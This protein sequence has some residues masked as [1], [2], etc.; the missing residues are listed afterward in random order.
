MA[1]GAIVRGEGLAEGGRYVAK[2]AMARGL[3][4]LHEVEVP[5]SQAEDVQPAKVLKVVL[6]AA[7][8]AKVARRKRRGETLRQV[9]ERLLLD[10]LEGRTPDVEAE[11][12]AGAAE[13]EEP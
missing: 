1:R 2:P 10:A 5:K 6:S 4:W 12:R 8:V 9:V 3:Y 11:S 13:A 7:L